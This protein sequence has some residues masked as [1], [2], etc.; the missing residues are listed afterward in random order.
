MIE[1]FSGTP[2]SGKSLDVARVIYRRLKVGKPVV[3][4]FRINTDLVK[5]KRKKFMYIDNSDLTPAVLE[6]ISRRY[7]TGRTIREDEILVVIDEAQLLFNARDWGQSGRKEWLS[8]FTQHR[9][10]G[11]KVLL[12][13]QFDRMLDRQIRSVIEYEYIHRKMSNF[14]IKGQIASLI[15]G[16]GLMICVKVWYPLHEVVDR[17]FYKAR[18][19]Y[20]KIYDTYNT[21]GA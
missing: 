20:F 5:S 13:A 21:F 15:C 8:F 11:I 17:E 9:K 14:G 1:L 7:F 12:V 3:A 18:K 10:L 16:G 2:G 19:R 4:N 6:R